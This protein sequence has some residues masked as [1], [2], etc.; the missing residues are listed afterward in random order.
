[1]V[2]QSH[3]F[4]S[5][6]VSEAE[7]HLFLPSDVPTGAVPLFQTSIPYNIPTVLLL[8]TLMAMHQMA[9]S[10]FPQGISLGFVRQH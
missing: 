10:S 7:A 4:P 5:V 1:M 3:C 8:I 9:L 6:T 2:L